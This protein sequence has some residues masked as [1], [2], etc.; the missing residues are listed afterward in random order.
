MAR[1]RKN[2]RTLIVQRSRA[3][4]SAAD[5]VT[6]LMTMAASRDVHI[7][8]DD[9]TPE[10][11]EAHI[12]HRPRRP[13]EHVD[14]RPELFLAARRELIEM[15]HAIYAADLLARYKLATFGRDAAGVHVGVDE[16]LARL[17]EQDRAW[18]ER[19]LEGLNG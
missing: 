12:W 17:G 19:E 8:S 11:V 9:R 18:A 3:L 5:Q 10:Q 4:K 6:R 13:E 2:P 7:R 16:A 14:N 1:R 15:S